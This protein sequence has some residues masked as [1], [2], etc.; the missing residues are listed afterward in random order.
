MESVPKNLDWVTERSNCS[1]SHLYLLLYDVIA[2]DVKAIQARS[3]RRAEFA[4]SRLDDAKFI[5]TKSSDW[6][7]G[8]RAVAGVVFELTPA[9]IDVRASTQ[10]G[11]KAMF[12]TTP[13]F[14][15]VGTCRLEVDGQPLELW[16]VSRK[17]LEDLFF[18]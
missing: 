3:E 10:D 13:S 16:Q 11:P 14:D 5:V 18:S 2:S 7:V 17:A 1:I 15:A 4:L 9:T 6:G 12:S 8:L